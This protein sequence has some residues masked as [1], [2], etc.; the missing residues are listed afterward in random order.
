V[1]GGAADLA[2]VRAAK[3]AVNLL[4]LRMLAGGAA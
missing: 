3:T 4:R 2:P 1:L